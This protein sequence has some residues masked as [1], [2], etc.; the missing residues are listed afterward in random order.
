MQPQATLCLLV[1]IFPVV[2]AC[3]KVMRCSIAF[4]QKRLDLFRA[5]LNV[6]IAA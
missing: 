3:Q 5:L 4:F 6:D 2:K 1:K